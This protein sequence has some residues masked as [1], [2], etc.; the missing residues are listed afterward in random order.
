[1]PRKRMLLAF[2]KIF[3][4]RQVFPVPCPRATIGQPLT[5][6]HDAPLRRRIQ[7]PD[8][9]R[10]LMAGHTLLLVDP[11]LALGLNE[12]QTA[13]DRS[14]HLLIGRRRASRQNETA[15]DDCQGQAHPISAVW[16]LFRNYSAPSV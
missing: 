14:M 12:R 2:L 9:E 4:R 5:I 8:H 15:A 10:H 3:F 7:R 13:L 16:E 11:A 1:M 6:V